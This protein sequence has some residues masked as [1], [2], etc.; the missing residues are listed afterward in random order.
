MAFRF[1]PKVV[2]DGLVLYLDA[3]NTKSYP[4]TGSNWFDLSGKNNHGDIIGGVTF[5]NSN[6]GSIVFDGVSD[7]V[8]INGNTDSLN[9]ISVYTVDIWI[10]S[11]Y[12][13][14]NVIL[15]KG[16]NTK[17]VIQPESS[18][19]WYGD[20]GVGY[21]SKFEESP[22]IRLNGSWL[23]ICISHSSNSARFYLNSVLVAERFISNISSNSSDIKLMSRDGTNS[24]SGSISSLKIY[25]RKLTDSEVLQNYSAKKSRFGL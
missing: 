19:W 1:S 2:T 13:G 9:S 20:A 14:N 15:E 7:Y 23:N 3:A 21:I 10:K 18:F 6:G 5:S 16:L 11:S 4:G 8:N 17:M 24:Q 22:S 25:N 12:T